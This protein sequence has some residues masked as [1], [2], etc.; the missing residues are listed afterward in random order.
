M[1]TFFTVDKALFLFSDAND[2]P[3]FPLGCMYKILQHFASGSI[4]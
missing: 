4:R 3:K 1:N 2:L